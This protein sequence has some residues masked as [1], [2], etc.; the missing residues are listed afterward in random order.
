MADAEPTPVESLALL[1]VAAPTVV[2]LAGW[3]RPAFG[4]PAALAVVVALAFHVARTRTAH[5]PRAPRAATAVA[6]AVEISL[7]VESVITKLVYANPDWHVRDAVL[8]DLVVRPWPVTYVVDGASLLMR[9]PI[10][11]FLPAAL[12][13]M[14]FGLRVAELALLAWTLAGV[15]LVFGLMRQDRPSVGATLVRV[16][17]FVL[18]SGMDI[19][20]HLAHHNPFAMGMHLEWWQ[21]LFQYSSQ[22]TQL[23]WVPNHA[24]PGWIAMAWLLGHGDR[25]LPVGTAA[26]FVVFAPLWSPLTAIGIAPLIAVGILREAARARRWR[27]W[28]PLVDAR[29]VVPIVASVVFV[30]PYLVLGGDTVASG[31]GSDVRF[32]GEEFGARY[33]EFVVYEFAGF[34]VLL[35][36]RDWR[37]ALVWTAALVLLALPFRRFGPY[38]DLAMRGSIAALAVLSL[39]TG[40]WLSGPWKEQRDVAGRVAAVALLAVGAVTP[41][42]EFARLALEPRWPADRNATLVDATRGTHYLAKPDGAWVRTFLDTAR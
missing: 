28:R 20:G 3:I 17:V 34:A 38:N 2:F 31:G 27:A 11:Y 4:V 41:A 15:L 40:H 8:R 6:V 16:A 39:R 14:P 23:F 35:L 5:G 9:A 10:G 1:Y 12:V 37:D 21:V 42:M 7:V 32:V 30:Y 13:G 29:V 36:R 33:V 19:V 18:F 26:L 25:P 24:L 22:T